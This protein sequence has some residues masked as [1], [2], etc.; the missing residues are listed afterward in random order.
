[1]IISH[2]AQDLQTPFR[3]FE[4]VR[5]DFREGGKRV[6]RTVVACQA[7]QLSANK[8]QWENPWA[9]QKSRDSLRLCATGPVSSGL[10]RGT[11][12]TETNSLRW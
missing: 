11:C 8:V 10:R 6:S 12:D 1:M 2:L 3:C 9:H 5:R 7:R 4:A